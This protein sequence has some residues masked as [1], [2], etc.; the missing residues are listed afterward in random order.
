MIEN[1]YND[2]I[3]LIAKG[4]TEKA[5]DLISSHIQKEK[6][7]IEYFEEILF[8]STRWRESYHRN[9][10]GVISISEF[11]VEKNKITNAL[12]NII[13]RLEKKELTWEG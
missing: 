6:I 13:N 1:I 12:L 7:E 4:E 5:I 2:S 8:L 11:L 3:T 9:I 10:I